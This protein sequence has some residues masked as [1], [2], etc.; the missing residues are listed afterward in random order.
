MEWTMIVVVDY[1]IGNLG[2]IVNMLRKIGADGVG[3]SDE[4]TISSA[5]K[6]ILPGVGAF[7]TGM[8]RL[9]Q[10]ALIE[11]LERKVLTN[12]T[13]ILGI[14]LGMQLLTEGS[15]EGML[16]G[17][18]WIAADTLRFDFAE[19][20]ER[21]RIPHMGWNTVDVKRNDSLFKDALEDAR[22]YFVHSYYVRCRHESDVVGTTR[23]G[24]DFHSAI[25]RDNIYGT[26]F[27]PEKSHAF[28]MAVLRAFAEL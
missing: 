17:L 16:S 1:G 5:D 23:Y 27:H 13:P 22:Y 7:D 15:E 20:N 8:D 28:G 2:S 3:A 24:S 19:T 25:Q 11:L 9:G 26:Q 6:L 18:G 14:C 10:S 4:A 12:R 21:L